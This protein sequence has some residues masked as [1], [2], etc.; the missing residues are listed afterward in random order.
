MKLGCML[1]RVMSVSDHEPSTRDTDTVWYD[2]SVQYRVLWI[3]STA[4][5]IGVRL[6]DHFVGACW[7]TGCSFESF[8][9]VILQS[10]ANQRL[11]VTS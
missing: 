10:I 1:W 11:I 3:Q 5:P 7:G 6:A 9:M 2:T 4:R 8:D